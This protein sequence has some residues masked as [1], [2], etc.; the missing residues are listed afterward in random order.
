MPLRSVGAT[1]QMK[2]KQRWRTRDP[3]AAPQSLPSP[4]GL[5]G[6]STRGWFSANA[7]IHHSAAGNLDN[8]WRTTDSPL[9]AARGHGLLS[10]GSESIKH[11]L[12]RRAHSRS[13][14]FGAMAK[15]LDLFH[16][17]KTF[18]ALRA[19]IDLVFPARDRIPDGSHQGFLSVLALPLHRHHFAAWMTVA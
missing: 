19:G 15:I 10:N 9:D 16:R 8:L 17:Q 14:T 5:S 13:S 18:P 6:H 12:G 3:P 4:R 11:P 1:T 2:D 7:L